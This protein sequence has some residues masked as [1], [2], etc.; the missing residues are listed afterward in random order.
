MTLIDP[1]WR[2][3]DSGGQLVKST[4]PGAG[5]SEEC[6]EC[7]PKSEKLLLGTAV[8][9]VRKGR[10]KKAGR[11]VEESRREDTATRSRWNERGCG[12]GRLT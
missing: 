5:Y 8:K 3:L 2:Q 1:E 11:A 6:A 7:A 12:V 10:R 9:N 4:C